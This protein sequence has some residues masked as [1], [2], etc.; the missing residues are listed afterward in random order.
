MEEKYDELYHYGV[1]G[2]KWGVRRAARK[3]AANERLEKKALNYDIKAAKLR[4]K[5]EKIHS[6]KDLERGNRAARKAASYDVRAAKARKKAAN[7]TSEFKQVMLEKKAAKLDYKSANQQLKADK[8]SKTEGYGTKAM[9]YSVKS[10]KIARKAAKS[11]MHIAQNEAYIAKMN[12][13]MSTI[14]DS[15][16]QAGKEYIRR[17]SAKTAQ[18]K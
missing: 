17:A 10:D 15:E 2:M 13:K 16:L 18:D 6:E 9:K 8:V 1:L 4:K 7:E 12:R 5:S 3:S 14:P 11:R